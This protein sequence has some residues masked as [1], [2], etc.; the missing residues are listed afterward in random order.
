M[1]VCT[2]TVISKSYCLSK[3]HKDLYKCFL[4]VFSNV[5]SYIIHEFYTEFYFLIVCVCAHT[6]AQARRGQCLRAGITGDFEPPDVGTGKGTQAV[7]QTVSVF[8]S[9]MF[10]QPKQVF[11]VVGTALV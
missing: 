9:E 8:T 11:T 4:P 5:S 6:C 1:S 2:F 3:G 7:Y 10:L